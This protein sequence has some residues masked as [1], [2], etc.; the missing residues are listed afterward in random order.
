MVCARHSPG[1]PKNGFVL[2]DFNTTNGLPRVVHQRERRADRRY[3]VSNVAVSVCAPIE[4]LRVLDVTMTHVPR[5]SGPSRL[6]LNVTQ[7]DLGWQI[8]DDATVDLRMPSNTAAPD[9]AGALTSA[10]VEGVSL[11]TTATLV[12]GVIIARN[13]FALAL[14][15]DDWGSCIAIALHLSLRGWSIV[16]PRH[17][18]VDDETREVEPFSKLLYI[19]TRIIPLLPLQYR[20][21][22]EASPWYSTGN[23]LGFYGVDPL[24]AQKSKPAD[25]KA[26][27]RAALIVDSSRRELLGAVYEPAHAYVGAFLPFSDIGMASASLVV[28]SIVPTADAVERWAASMFVTA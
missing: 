27:L 20:R 9:V 22:L 18:F 19:P 4:I 16:T 17:A 26:T 11:L 24:H 5:H 28:G 7:T 21:A 14:V 23:E 6:A 15:G 12:T 10:M 13:D 8:V 2:L 25:R 3:V 1:L